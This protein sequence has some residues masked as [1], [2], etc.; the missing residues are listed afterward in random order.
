MKF[1][2]GAFAFKPF[3]TKNKKESYYPTDRGTSYGSSE[4]GGLTVTKY[5]KCLFNNSGLKIQSL[6]MDDMNMAYSFDIANLLS[7]VT[8]NKKTYCFNYET[9]Y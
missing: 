5:I 3:L 2:G 9:R 4:D 6:I 1:Y 8:D 7:G